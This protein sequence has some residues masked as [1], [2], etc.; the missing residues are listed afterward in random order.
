MR[1]CASKRT[2]MIQCFDAMVTLDEDILAVKFFT[3]VSLYCRQRNNKTILC[4]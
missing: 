1:E 2:V 4:P 3:K